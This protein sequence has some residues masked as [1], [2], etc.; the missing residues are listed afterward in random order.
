MEHNSFKSSLAFSRMLL[1]QPWIVSTPKQEANWDSQ[2]PLIGS[3]LSG[4][5]QPIWYARHF[6]EWQGYFE[7]PLSQHPQGKC[8]P[9]RNETLDTAY[10]KSN[11][12]ELGG[13]LRALTDRALTQGTGSGPKLRLC[14]DRLLS[15]I[16]RW[17]WGSF[18]FLAL[19]V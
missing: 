19:S 14:L 16:L 2:V 13:H 15:L 7:E 6:Q 8:L 3:Q 4:L 12:G 5:G 11:S 9:G 18:K 1:A 17:R 10:N